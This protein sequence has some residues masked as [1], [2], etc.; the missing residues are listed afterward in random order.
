MTNRGMLEVVDVSVVVVSSLA[1]DTPEIGTANGVV[2]G[3]R[4]RGG[5]GGVRS[6]GG[7]LEYGGGG[8]GEGM[9]D[10]RM[11]RSRP[12]RAGSVPVVVRG[13][14][15]SLTTTDVMACR[16]STAACTRTG[17]WNGMFRGAGGMLLS[18]KGLSG[19]DVDSDV[20]GRSSG[21]KRV[22]DVVD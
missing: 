14:F 20:P 8:A 1:G 2:S 19:A 4:S 5:R 21:S 17:R 15:W 7:G 18:A 12:S 13:T 10:G 16:A 6:R 11:D 9:R 22:S 3:I